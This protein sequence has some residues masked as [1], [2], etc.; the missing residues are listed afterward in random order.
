MAIS[1]HLIDI[2]YKKNSENIFLFVFYNK[3]S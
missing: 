3:I 2:L 1:Y